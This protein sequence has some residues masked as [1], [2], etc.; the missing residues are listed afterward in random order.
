MS[1]LRAMLGPELV[2]ALEY[3]VDERVAAALAD[4]ENGAEPT[5]LSIPEA[6]DFMRVSESTIARMIRDGRLSS[7][8]V[9]RRRIIRR[10]DL[11]R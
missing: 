5:W 1:D 2:E 9:G 10:S 3:L 11:D 8:C 4:R 7:E 6:A